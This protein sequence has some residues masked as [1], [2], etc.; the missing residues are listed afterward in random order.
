MWIHSARERETVYVSS[1]RALPYVHSYI[2]ADLNAALNRPLQSTSSWP[3]DRKVPKRL[4]DQR[5]LQ[6][7]EAGRVYLTF[8]FIHIDTTDEMRITKKIDMNSKKCLHVNILCVCKC[9]YII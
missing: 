3:L 7:E 6:E 5:T 2:V 1:A 9:Q 4:E 8:K